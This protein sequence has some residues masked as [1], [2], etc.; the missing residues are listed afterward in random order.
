[1]KEKAQVRQGRSRLACACAPATAKRVPSMSTPRVRLVITLVL[2]LVA[3]CAVFSWGQWLSK[4]HQALAGFETVDWEDAEPRVAS[5]EWVLVDAR[6]EKK[7]A[8]GH[9]PG[10]YSLPAEAAPEYLQFAVAEWPRN[11][12]VVV[13]C[14][15][16]TCSLAAELADRL[17]RESGVPDVRV[18]T[19]NYFKDL[20]RRE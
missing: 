9:L 20:H 12:V 18:L 19:G 15:S 4:N 1:M 7:F 10:A 16:P 13:Y 3:A 17:Q 2:A 11:G 5:G 14:G 6:S 8:Y